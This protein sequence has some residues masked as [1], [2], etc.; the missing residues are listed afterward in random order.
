[1]Y[2]WSSTARRRVDRAA[3]D[4]EIPLAERLNVTGRPCERANGWS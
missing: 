3:S 2:G 1:M 4:C